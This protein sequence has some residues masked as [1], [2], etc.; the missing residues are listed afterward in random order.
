MRNDFEVKHNFRNTIRKRNTK[1]YD[2]NTIDLSHLSHM[3]SEDWHLG[4]LPFKKPDFKVN[5]YPENQQTQLAQLLKP[6]RCRHDLLV[7][8]FEDFLRKVIQ[9]MIYDGMAMFEICKTNKDKEYVLESFNPETVKIEDDRAVQI[10]AKEDLYEDQ[11]YYYSGSIDDLFI[12][13]IPTWLEGGKGL[14]SVIQSLHLESN[15]SLVATKFLKIGTE[16]KQHYFDYNVFHENS[17]L[18]VLKLTNDSGWDMR[19]SANEHITEF[20]WVYRALKFRTN[21][22]RLREYIVDKINSDLI[23]KL[24]RKGA[25]IQKIE[26]SGI[27]TYL[28]LEKLQDDLILGKV[29]FFEALDLEKLNE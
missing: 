23:P 22:A 29:G 5:V 20:Y 1:P 13:E 19:Q 6:S 4:I 28:E 11:D 2:P 10:V 9:L 21:Q 15:R 16:N 26:L 7:D 12:I 25:T 17:N 3:Y 8:A 14:Q 27:R 18:D 24:N